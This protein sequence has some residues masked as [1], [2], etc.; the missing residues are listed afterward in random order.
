M[1]KSINLEVRASSADLHVGASV[2][3]EEQPPRRMRVGWTQLNTHSR[4]SFRRHVQSN[5]PRLTPR[6]AEVG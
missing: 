6:Q 4:A 2:A 3:D 1:R 5:R